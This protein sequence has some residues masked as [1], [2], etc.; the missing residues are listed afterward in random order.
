MTTAP[1]STTTARVAI[2]F[3]LLCFIWGS[4]WAFIKLGLDDLPPITFVSIRFAVAVILLIIIT[5]LRKSRWPRTVAEWRFL[6]ITGILSFGLNYGLL[7]WGE[8]HTSSGLAALLQATIPLFGLLLAQVYLPNE[9]L[10]LKRFAG[11]VI[12]L[13]GVGIIFARQMSLGDRG[14]I[15]GGAAIIV[16]AFF[17]AYSN[18]LVKSRGAS[19]DLTVLVGGQM[20]CGFIPLAIYA[21]IREGNPLQIHW[22]RNSVIS[23]LYLAVLGSVTAF[24][25][26]YWLV[27]HMDVTKTLLISLVTPVMAVLIGVVFLNE[28]VTWH[29]A[30]GAVC[31]FAGIVMVVAHRRRH[32]P[33]GT[34]SVLPTAAGGH[35]TEDVG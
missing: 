7:F 8:N 12:G 13:V 34:E 24:L 29:L 22:T 11:V 21:L 32:R 35:S 28:T 19:Y 30:V 16:G 18:V 6:A 33:L 25:L 17:A 4:T 20:F 9:S 27:R 23:V 2:V 14:A 1:P 26:Y 3:I 10:T 15:A 31:I 5:R